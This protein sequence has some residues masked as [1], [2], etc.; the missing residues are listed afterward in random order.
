MQ[1]LEMNRQLLLGGRGG[2][3][4][5]LGFPF[6]LLF[7][8]LGPWLEVL[9]YVAMTLLWL[10]GLI[11]FQAFWT[12]LLAVI[13]LGMLLSTSALLLDEWAFHCKRKLAHTLKLF[14]V[15]IVEN[16]GYRQLTALWRLLGRK[17]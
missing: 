7:E 9:G 10:S 14:A 17:R 6:V 1:S 4:G 12:F 3:I 5:W 2:A 16:L 13:G 8:W 15:A 11:S